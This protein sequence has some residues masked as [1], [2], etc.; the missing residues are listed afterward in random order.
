MTHRIQDQPNRLDG[1][2]ADDLPAHA[3]DALA[4]RGLR[5][6]RGLVVRGAL[7]PDGVA[8]V[9]ARASDPYGLALAR[10]LAR[11]VVARGLA[12][13]SGGAEGCDAAAHEG[14]LEA[15]GATTV[16]LPAGHDHLY[17]PRHA[18]LF[19]RVVAAGGA[20]VSACWP[21]TTITR[22]RFLARNGVIAQLATRG[23]IVVRAHARSGSLSTARAAQALGRPVAAVAGAIGEA[24]SEGC[25]D[26]LDGGA[27]PMLGPRSLDRWLG[28]EVASA[29]W[30]VAARGQPAPWSDA[31]ATSR[32]T[33][34]EPLA[35]VVLDALRAEP[36]LD[37]DTIAVRTGTPISALAAAMLALEIDGVIERWPGG[38]FHPRRAQG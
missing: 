4:A 26:L 10:Q 37:L 15:G 9:G 17:P 14:A 27:V 16:V 36:G 22:G 13:I 38:R 19:E 29:R 8:I 35:G 32:A 28:R 24:L 20:V 34:S 5:Y 30:P 23:V 2:L 33:A 21:T 12:V 3:R 31:P 7:A 11:E 1:S 6:E 18:P 25:H